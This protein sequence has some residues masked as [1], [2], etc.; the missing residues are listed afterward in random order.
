MNGNRSSLF[1][2]VLQANNFAIGHCNIMRT[3]I[4]C[5]RGACIAPSH[6]KKVAAAPHQ[7]LKRTI[8]KEC[9]CKGKPRIYCCPSHVLN[10]ILHTKKALQAATVQE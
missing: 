2:N 1:F 6:H 10:V 5:K 8:S 4:A 9:C 7:Q 3:H